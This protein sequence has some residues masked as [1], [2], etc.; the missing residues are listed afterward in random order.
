MLVAQAGCALG[1]Y[2]RKLRV[3]RRPVPHLSLGRRRPPEC[4][5][6]LAEETIECERYVRRTS[7][8]RELRS[9]TTPRDRVCLS[10]DALSPSC[11]K[12]LLRQELGSIVSENCLLLLLGL[13]ERG[14][15]AGSSTSH[16]CAPP[17]MLSEVSSSRRGRCALG[18]G[19]WNWRSD[20]GKVVVITALAV[21]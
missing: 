2:T 20:T 10:P 11:A 18:R 3:H 1:I 16:S 12:P 13:R 19:S 8:G 9:R 21:S 5:Q 4:S 14:A 17:D 6:L 7:R 15:T